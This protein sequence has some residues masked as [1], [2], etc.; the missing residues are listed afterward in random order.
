MVDCSGR[1]TTRAGAQ[2]HLDRGAKR[3]LV[4]APPKTLGDCDAVLL[5]G[6]NL[7]A[8]DP[9]GHR[10]ISMGS[11]T[12]NALAP[13]VKVIR[14][15]C[16]IRCGFFSPANRIPRWSTCRSRPGKANCFR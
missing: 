14:E 11:R 5:K 8:Y 12:T 1:S 10:I 2:L 15:H 16:G 6:I 7:E 3:V 4:S 9:H 13:V